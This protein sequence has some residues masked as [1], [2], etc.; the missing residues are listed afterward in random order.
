[1]ILIKLNPWI[2]MYYIEYGID[3]ISIYFVLILGYFNRIGF[4][5]MNYIGAFFCEI[6]Y[7][8]SILYNI[9]WK[10]LS[11]IIYVR[12]QP[13]YHYYTILYHNI[14]FSSAGF[15]IAKINIYEHA[16]GQKP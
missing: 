8:M 13:S 14:D 9:E 7:L 15:L 6:L 12:E 3:W 1:M 10:G 5:E 4:I 11:T 2:I 16:N